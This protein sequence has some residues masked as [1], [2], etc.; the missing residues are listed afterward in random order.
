VKK[1]F[2]VSA[3]VVGMA[4]KADIK[5]IDR[6]VKELGLNKEQRR[7]LHDEITGQYLTFDEIRAIAEDIVKHTLKKGRG[8]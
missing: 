1:E 8:G 3:E 4:R 6:L 5:Q 7:L 2:P